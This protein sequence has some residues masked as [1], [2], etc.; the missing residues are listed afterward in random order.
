MFKRLT[1]VGV[2]ENALCPIENVE[3]SKNGP[4]AY[5]RGPDRT[6]DQNYS[7]TAVGGQ[8]SAEMKT[9]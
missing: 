7:P 6:Q 9:F 8:L 3:W 2:F 4:N 5:A 1:E